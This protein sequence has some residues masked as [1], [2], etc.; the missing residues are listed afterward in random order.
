M[1]LDETAVQLMQDADRARADSLA[2]WQSLIVLPE[3]ASAGEAR[4]FAPYAGDRCALDLVGR[5]QIATGREFLGEVFEISPVGLRV[6]GPEI[7][8]LGD[9]CSVNIASVGLIE[10]VVVRVS[11]NAFVLGVMAPQR[12]LRRLAKRLNW[13]LRRIN[14]E[15]VI[16]NRGHERIEMNCAEA[17]IEASDGQIYGC[18]IFD[19][20]KSGAALQLGPN[21]LRFSVGQPVRLDGRPGRVVRYFSGGVAIKF[22]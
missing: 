5:C 15:D 22:D 19:I 20:S 3:T 9:R 17:T 7:A 8:R 2:L 6:R 21:S 13:Q 12:R 10:G 14:N 11:Q 18:G 16:E 4:S 1:L